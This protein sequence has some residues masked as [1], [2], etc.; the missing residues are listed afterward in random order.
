MN[1]EFVNAKNKLALVRFVRFFNAH[2]E[3]EE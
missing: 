1:G 2:D 3:I